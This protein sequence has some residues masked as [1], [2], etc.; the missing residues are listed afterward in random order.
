MAMH[1]PELPDQLDEL[2]AG[3]VLGN[4]S[5]EEAEALQRYLDAH[6]EK[7]QE[8]QGLQE[9]LEML[10]YAL[11]PVPLPESLHAAIAQIPQQRPKR[12]PQIG[13]VRH[14]WQRKV[15]LALAGL[16]A[17][18]AWS[19]Y[20]LHQD[21]QLAQAETA[22]QKDV[23]AMLQNPQTHLVSLQGME[24]APQAT[25]RVVMTPGEPQSVLIIQ[26]LPPL[27]PGQFYKL[28]CVSQGKKIPSE[29]FNAGK[30]GTVLAKLP[31]PSA[32]DV[33]GIVITLEKDS[34]T[35]PSPGPMVMTSRL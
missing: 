11:P 14:L 21:L 29:S 5:A 32:D 6:P 13:I 18:L 28:W 4:L 9:T 27:P 10:P 26:N 23:V 19:N 7:R 12:W 2:L 20:R 17:A 3:Y 35:D 8:I 15:S 31:T 1:E 25:G 22:Y 30:N 33:T 34:Q 16:V 24:S